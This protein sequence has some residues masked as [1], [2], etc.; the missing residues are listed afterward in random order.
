MTSDARGLTAGFAG[1]GLNNAA[2]E[3]CNESYPRWSFPC[4]RR[5]AGNRRGR[6]TVTAADRVSL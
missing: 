1:A 4:P 5:G 2:N 3:K 6:F